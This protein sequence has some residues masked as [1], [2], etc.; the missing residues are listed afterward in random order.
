MYYLSNL[1]IIDSFNL[2]RK[3]KSTSRPWSYRNGKMSSMEAVPYKH[4]YSGL[5]LRRRFFRVTFMITDISYVGTDVKTTGRL[6]GNNDDP[7]LFRLRE[8]VDQLNKLLNGTVTKKHKANKSTKTLTTTTA[9]A[10]CR[11]IEETF[12]FDID[13]TSPV[14]FWSSNLQNILK[15]IRM[16]LDNTNNLRYRTEFILRKYQTTCTV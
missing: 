5:L 13:G 6:A 14:S 10:M 11:C 8:E 9:A 12:G 16:P 3:C 1:H 4:G 2:F 7:E 15:S